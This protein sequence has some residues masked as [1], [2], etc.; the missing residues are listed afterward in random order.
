MKRGSALLFA[1]ASYLLFLAVFIYA[2][3]FIGGFGVPGCIDGPADG[4]IG[5]AAAVNLLLISLFGLQHSVMARQG[6]KRWWTRLVPH[7]VE[8]SMYV[9][10]TSL[11]LG[12]LFWQWRPMGLIVW[13]VQSPVLQATLYGLFAAGWTT[14]LVTT[15]LISHF[16]LF[17]LRQAWIYFRGQPAG[18]IRFVM[19]G[20]Y[21]FVRHPLYVGWLL[22]FW[23]TPTM[24]AAHL[25]FAAAMTAYILIAIRYEERDLLVEHGARLDSAE[26]RGITIPATGMLLPSSVV[27]WP[28]FGVKWD[29]AT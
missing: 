14:V 18:P 15:F 8:R 21:R 23:A 20:P 25:L 4:P 19:P 16:D 22:A 5:A 29:Y 7:P 10:L 17:G 6:F 1:L 2:I 24:G 26:P 28:K 12:L 13:D 27:P 11:A 9:L 3:G